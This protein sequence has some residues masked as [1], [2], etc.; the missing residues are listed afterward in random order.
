MKTIIITAI[1]ISA[2][3]VNAQ[4]LKHKEIKEIIYNSIESNF[5]SRFNS[6][7]ELKDIFYGKCNEYPKHC[8]KLKFDKIT[9]FRIIGEEN[10]GE[11][12]APSNSTF[13]NHLIIKASF[14]FS[15]KAGNIDHYGN[16]IVECSLRKIMD[17]YEI[18]YIKITGVK[19]LHEYYK[20]V[21]SEEF[22]IL[23]RLTYRNQ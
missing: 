19:G 21:E 13:S 5:P 10:E 7:R 14:D 6:Y 8:K 12:M 17:G 4:K 20:S 22:Y 23:N 1:I 15:Y 18:D 3:S 11:E 16:G 9:D 2:F